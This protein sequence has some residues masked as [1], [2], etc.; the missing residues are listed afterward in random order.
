MIT[1]KLYGAERCHK[2]QYYKRFLKERNLQYVFLDVEE[3]K[4]A[5]NELRSLYVHGKLHFPTLTIN[6]KRL[7][8][9]SDKDLEKWIA[10]A[11]GL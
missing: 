8:N 1:I 2:T 7:R 10:K 6:N 4:N 3:N 9:P 5:A 11:E